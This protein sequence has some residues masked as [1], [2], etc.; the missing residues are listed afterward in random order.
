MVLDN[1]KKRVQYMLDML[2]ILW[3]VDKKFFFSTLIETIIYSALPFF[4]LMFTEKTIAM[5]TEKGAYKS[6]IIIVAMLLIIICVT[7]LLNIYI[8]TLNN[9]KG[10]LLG[11][12]LYAKI[13]DK[14][15]RMDFDKFQTKDVQDKRMMATKAFAG[16]S[17]AQLIAHFK[18]IAGSIIIILGVISIAV[19]ADWLILIMVS[20]VVIMSSVR[21]ISEKR[22][23]YDME[24]EITPINRRIEYFINMS[25]DLSA[26]KEIR[27]YHTENALM[28]KYNSLY[29]K[30]LAILKKNFSFSQTTKLIS[31]IL[32]EILEFAIYF[33]LGY[34]V[35]V[36][37]DMDIAQF[38]MLA[39]AVRT[40]K[41][42]M[43]LLVDSYGE[44]EKNS[45]YLKDYFE[46]INIPS[47]F[48]LP[49]K[50]QQV[51]QLSIIRFENVSFKYPG[52]DLYVL[53]NID[54]EIKSGEKLSVVGENGSGKTT[55]IKL[56]MRLYEPTEGRITYNGVD[57]K[58]L[59]YNKYLDCFS[60][61]FQDFK[62]YAFTILENI[63]MFKNVPKQ[64]L[65]KILNELKLTSKIKKLPSGINTFMYKIYDENGIELSGGQNQKI[66]IARALVKNAPIYILDEPTAALDPRAENEI[67]NDFDNMVKGKT[68]VYISHRLSS[69]IYSDNIIVL[70]NGNLI[71]QGTHNQLIS[72]NGR[73]AE[74]FNMQA[75][76]YVN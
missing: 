12:K 15:L 27:L 28:E 73:Y 38:S 1:M 43:L 53:K 41:N 54:L 56:L 14:C 22:Y 55:L 37:K 44:I 71:E 7:Q 6:Y 21:I 25:S 63:S 50:I 69:C 64:Q 2:K 68:A 34:H 61:V 20:I 18:N 19:T 66:A 23:Q 72:Q 36:I 10:N 75:K 11:Q 29:K 49:T 39:L 60:T 30:T 57:I 42:A 65:K 4:Q 62:I 31:E 67:F 40:L 48:N 16:G 51:E 26:A 46:F 3:S 13:F 76:Y 5:L 59:P 58:E 9:I 33:I 17:L 45:M 52:T 32:S 47:E 35:L 24:Q 8:N 70:E 74:L